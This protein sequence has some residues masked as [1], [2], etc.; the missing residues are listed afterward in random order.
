[1]TFETTDRSSLAGRLMR[2]ARIAGLV[3]VASLLTLTLLLAWR[4][5]RKLSANLQQDFRDRLASVSNGVT[6]LLRSQ[7]E[8]LQQIL[9]TNLNVAED[10]VRR[11]GGLGLSPASVSW[12]AKD[13]VSGETHPTVLPQMAVGGTWLGQNRDPRQTTALV[14]EVARLVGGT[15][16]VFQ[17]MTPGGD[18]LRVATNVVAKDGRRAIGTFIPADNPDHSSN[19]VIAAVLAG[20]RY[21]GRA[22]VVD[23]WY[24]TVYQPISQ[25]G[26][27]I[28]MLYVGVR[29]ENVPS[30]RKSIEQSRVGTTGEVIVLGGSAAQRGKYIIGPDSIAPGS[31]ALGLTDARG[32]SI[33]GPMVD[34]ARKSLDGSVALYS[35]QR[36]LAGGGSEARIAGVSYFAPWDWVVI[37]E[38]PER[39]FSGAL[40]ATRATIL[41]LVVLLLITG[42]ALAWA[43]MT[44]V[45]RTARAVI[46]PV[47]SLVVAAERLAQGDVSSDVAIEGDQEIARLGAS[48]QRILLAER[49]LAES[50]RAMA[51]GDLSVEIHSRGGHDVLGQSIEGI[52]A[53]ERE[54]VSAASRIASGDLA[55]ELPL[56]SPDDR[57]SGAM[58]AILRTEREL[59]GALERVG[60]GDLGVSVA[61]RGEHDA[62]S[63]AVARI[64]TAERSLAEAATRIAAGDLSATITPRSPQDELSLA[65][66]RILDAERRLSEAAERIAS[67]DVSVPVVSRGAQDGLG[68]S[69]IKLQ[70]TIQALSQETS[71][72]IAAA[73]AGSLGVRG[74]TSRFA[75][76]FHALVQGINHLLDASSG[77]LQ[78][79]AGV[80]S[81]IAANDLTL[82]MTGRYHGDHAA[83]AAD[84]NRMASD[85]SASMSSIADTAARLS[86]SANE[87]GAAGETVERSASVATAQAGQVA[88][89]AQGV[90]STVTG[91]AA[92]AEEMS[93]S[94]REIAQSATSAAR[95]AGRAVEVAG[96]ADQTVARLGDSSSQ[97]TEIVKTI[98]EIA[99]H[100]NLLALNAT[101]EAARAGEAG[102]GFAVVANEVKELAGSTARATGE[103]EQKIEAIQRDSSDAMA[104]LRQI[105][106]IISDISAL[107]TAIAGAVEE[108]TATTAEMTRGIAGASSGV[109]EIAGKIDSVAEAT[110]RSSEAIARSQVAVEALLAMAAELKGLVGRFRYQAAAPQAG[111][112][113][114]AAAGR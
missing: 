1:M 33:Y 90:S 58:N 71:R 47:E 36:Q 41:Q 27:V 29:Q 26:Q 98:R 10:L 81:G 30:L 48:M 78:E 17:R 105:S 55:R 74:D 52:L 28:G 59:S 44:Y 73:S 32:D 4:L 63:R 69:F 56:R 109:T 25:G 13:Q 15:V 113:S 39:E 96:Q 83:F 24:Q 46:G 53:A 106:T 12:D 49:E 60:A 85:L 67:G 31:D 2:L 16:T 3:P 87:L 101:I 79:A 111:A 102:R 64:V 21:E 114:L 104:A 9:L 54:V 88:Q 35:F 40:T 80:L 38:A 72:L 23:A 93:A 77:P 89:A 6:G 61:P 62:L 7:H 43:T 97:I 82:R 20:K 95:V 84:V 14:D 50:A 57:L 75:G 45:R 68:Q 112:S 91:V 19:P 86:V 51:R 65:F 100:T 92:G 66:A 18:M 94:I 34:S 110:G 107:Q 76:D 37:A 22:F 103:I 8:S 70:R 11:R 108:Q 5:D 42:G 99:Q